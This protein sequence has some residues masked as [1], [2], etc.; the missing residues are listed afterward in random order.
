MKTRGPFDAAAMPSMRWSK[1]TRWMLLRMEMRSA[2]WPLP[3]G[4]KMLGTVEKA[5]TSELVIKMDGDQPQTIRLDPRSF[6]S[7]DHGYAVTIHKSQGATVDQ[8]YV[9][10][11]RSMDR[12]LAY[13]AMTRHREA[14]RVFI[15]RDDS[16]DWATERRELRRAQRD[17]QPT[18]SG[19]SLG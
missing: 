13:V 10:A 19:P 15:R 14:M 4:A 18:R 7:F 16:P 9:L 11:S 2:A 5:T 6:Q 3:T 8:A 17:H 1:A 12:H